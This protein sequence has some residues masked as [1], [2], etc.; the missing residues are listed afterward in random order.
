[1][2]AQREGEEEVVEMEGHDD[3]IAQRSYCAWWTQWRE[4]SALLFTCRAGECGVASG[5]RR[6]LAEQGM[7]RGAGGERRELR[8][9]WR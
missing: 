7:T 6:R 8:E 1:M 3:T 4:D 9:S 2:I 5:E